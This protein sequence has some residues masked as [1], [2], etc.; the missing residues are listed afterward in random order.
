METAKKKTLTTDTHI[1]KVNQ[2]L[3]TTTDKNIKRKNFPPFLFYFSLTRTLSGVLFWLPF[4]LLFEY[5]YILS[6]RSGCGTFM[7]PIK[8]VGPIVFCRMQLAHATIWTWR[9]RNREIYNPLPFSLCISR[10]LNQLM[11]CVAG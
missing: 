8:Y 3:L 5:I 2:R 4:Q 11:L 7:W 9:G 10:I 1:F 6:W